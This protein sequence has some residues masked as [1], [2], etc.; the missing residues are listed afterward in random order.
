MYVLVLLGPFSPYRCLHG[1]FVKC[2]CFNFI[3]A[4]NMMIWAQLVCGVARIQKGS[5]LDYVND[6]RTIHLVSN[7]HGN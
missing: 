6:A 3:F 7:L 5:V 1:F 4:R 2:S